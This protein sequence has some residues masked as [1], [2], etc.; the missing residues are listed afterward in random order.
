M[1]NLVLLLTTLLGACSGAS[2]GGLQSPTSEVQDCSQPGNVFGFAFNAK[3]ASWSRDRLAVTLV[4]TNPTNQPIS[5]SAANVGGGM[6]AN[7]SPNFALLNAQGA[8]YEPDMSS[9]GMQM[10]PIMGNINP[11]ISKEF[12]LSFEVPRGSYVLSVGRLVGGYPATIQNDL[13]KC[14]LPSA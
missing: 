2:T 12:T 11:G 4:V 10:V 9:L 7:A 3:N 5:M 6:I 14:R 1:R 8:R 13:Y